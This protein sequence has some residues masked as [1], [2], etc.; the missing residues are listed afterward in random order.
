MQ[1][2]RKHSCIS[3]FWTTN[4]DQITLERKLLWDVEKIDWKEVFMTLTGTLVYLP[5]SFKR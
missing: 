2:C 1:N 3:N 5:N 4:L